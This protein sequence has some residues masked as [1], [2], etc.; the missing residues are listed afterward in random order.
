MAAQLPVVEPL[1]EVGYKMRPPLLEDVSVEGPLRIPI[2]HALDTL[3]QRDAIEED[4]NWWRYSK[5]A[6]PWLFF[7]LLLLAVLFGLTA[8]QQVGDLKMLRDGVPRYYQLQASSDNKYEAGLH[9]D[10]RNL[11]F[12]NVVLTLLP[13]ILSLLVLGS[14]PRPGLRKC[15]QIVLALILFVGGCSALVAFSVSEHQ[16]DWKPGHKSGQNRV[17]RCYELSPW[18]NEPCEDRRGVATAATVLDFLL[19]LA[20]ITA[21]VVVIYT[22]LTGDYKLL[23]TGWRQ[24]ERDLEK[25]KVKKNKHNI[26]AHRVRETRLTMTIIAL[27]FVIA[28][29]IASC[30]FSILIHQ[31]HDVT[32]LR[33]ER[34]RTSMFFDIPAE[35][36]FE[37]AGWTARNT[38]LRYALCSVGIIAILANLIPWR[39]RVI[40]WLFAF[41]YLCVGALALVAF[42]FD[43]HEM[44]RSRD[45]GCIT[46]PYQNLRTDAAFNQNSLLSSRN[47]ELNCINSPYV[48]TAF[49]DF[50]VAIA[51]I[52]YLFNEYIFR[53]KSVHSQRKYPWFAIHKQETKLDSRRPVRCELTSHVM[54]AKE[55]YYKHRF[56]AGSG[57]TTSGSSAT[58]MTSESLFDGV[59]PPPPPPPMM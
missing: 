22:T 30:V 6:A 1:E 52:I 15:L 5:F 28:F 9:K 33:S 35:H 41:V 24:Q 42:S 39:S 7:M 45:G 27:L 16:I 51:V 13:A 19:G 23:R 56:L 11:R 50:V 40:A 34:G 48:A 53:W 29:A 38:R 47:L 14:K 25:E 37:E 18:T 8:F 59:V 44:R 4:Y 3:E 26:K 32:L 43:V 54:T 21:F 31:D 57:T 49:F 46:R 36:Q 58:S 2:P 55:Y 20:A 17:Q 10:T 12:A